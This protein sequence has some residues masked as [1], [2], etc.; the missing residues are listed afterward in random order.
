MRRFTLIELLVVIAII[1]IL[2]GMLLPALQRARA[3]AR[4]A[5]CVSQ[6]KQVL[7]AHTQYAG[8]Y[9]GMIYIWSDGN[10]PF[11]GAKTVTDCRSWAGLFVEL[12]LLPKEVIHCPL[13]DRPGAAFNGQFSYGGYVYDLNKAWMTAERTKKYG[14]FWGPCLSSPW[15]TVYR[16][17][18]MRS[19]ADMVLFMDTYD[20]GTNHA[21]DVTMKGKGFWGFNPE[22]PDNYNYTPSIHHNDVSTAGYPDGHAD[23]PSK[24]VLADKGFSGVM[25]DG[26]YTSI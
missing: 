15:S 22:A 12:G 1:A 5:T 4:T 17:E 9:D 11:Q 14:N 8:D 19:P 3:K 25:I 23:N 26:I 7:A 10:N 6:M 13:Q 24:G 20:N 16:L 2:A 18:Q 21:S